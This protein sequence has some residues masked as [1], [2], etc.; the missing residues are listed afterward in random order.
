[1][2]P[3]Y[4]H[5]CYKTGDIKVQLLSDLPVKTDRL[6]IA[7]REDSCVDED[8]ILIAPPNGLLEFLDSVPGIQILRDSV[9]LMGSSCSIY[10]HGCHKRGDIKVQRLPDLPVKTDRLF[11]AQREDSCVDK[12]DILIAPPNGT[13]VPGLG[14]KHSDPSRQCE[15]DGILMGTY[16]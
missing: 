1:M 14:P 9:N 13:G 15:F 8:D 12:D 11:I 5:G 3:I 4:G 16:S 10:G 7:Q 6:F 2:Q